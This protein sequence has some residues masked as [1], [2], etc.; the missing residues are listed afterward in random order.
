MQ[1]WVERIDGAVNLGELLDDLV[2]ALL[3]GGEELLERRR[4]RRLRL[5]EVDHLREG[6]RR[7][8][9]LLRVRRAKAR[10]GALRGR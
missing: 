5:D 3:E 4:R 8:G 2:L 6:G 9:S 10:R 7:H 1:R